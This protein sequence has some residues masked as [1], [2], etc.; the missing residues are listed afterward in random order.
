MSVR[1]WEQQLLTHFKNNSPELYVSLQNSKDGAE[2]LESISQAA[3]RAYETLVCQYLASGS[4]QKSA[5]AFAESEVMQQFI[6]SVEAS[7]LGIPEEPEEDMDPDYL[8][9]LNGL[10]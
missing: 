3:Q 8:E 7:T 6:L 4:Q 9:F 1:Y 10:S 2:I 5:E